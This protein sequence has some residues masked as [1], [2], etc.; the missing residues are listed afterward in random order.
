MIAKMVIEQ[1]NKLGFDFEIKLVNAEQYDEVTSELIQYSDTLAANMYGE[2]YQTTDSET[3]VVTTERSSFDVVAV[4]YQMLDTTAFSML[5]VFSEKFSGGQLDFGNDYKAL[6]HFTGFNNESYNTLINEAYEAYK[7]GDKSTL[8]AKLHEAE[9]LLLEQM[10]VIPIFEYQNIVL[11][12][13]DIS[14]LE[15]SSWGSINFTRAKL[16]NWEAHVP[17]DEGSKEEE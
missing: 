8:S 6:G 13:S 11:E 2:T 5:S 14:R 10:P 1:W 4:D 15:Y 3:P 16:K 9:K 12:S 17:V 7:S